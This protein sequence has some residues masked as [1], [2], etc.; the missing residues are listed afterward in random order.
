PRGRGSGFW[1]CCLNCAF[2]TKSFH[3][4]NPQNKAVVI[5]DLYGSFWA[6]HSPYIQPHSFLIFSSQICTVT[7]LHCR[8]TLLILFKD[9][10][11]CCLICS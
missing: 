3:I 4:S 11:C 7:F 8:I 10:S 9:P 2:I 5:S 6:Q 1:P